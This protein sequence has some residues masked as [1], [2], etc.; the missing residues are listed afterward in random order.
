MEAWRVWLG[1]QKIV[2]PKYHRGKF[3][4]QAQTDPSFLLTEGT[5][6]VQ[7]LPEE[8]KKCMQ[9]YTHKKKK[10]TDKRMNTHMRKRRKRA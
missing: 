6:Q 2:S 7:N 9:E 3:F 5:R 1:R 4:L 10:K 8:E